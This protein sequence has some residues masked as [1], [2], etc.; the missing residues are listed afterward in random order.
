VV[1]AGDDLGVF[2]EGEVDDGVQG[3]TESSRAWS[4]SSFASGNGAR[5]RLETP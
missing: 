5:R 1:D 4:V 2:G 3:V